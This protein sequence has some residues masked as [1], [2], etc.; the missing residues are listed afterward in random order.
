MSPDMVHVRYEVSA[1]NNLVLVLG[2]GLLSA[3]L[4]GL[5][6]CNTASFCEQM[7][8]CSKTN[9]SIC[10]FENK[11]SITADAK[12]GKDS[13]VESLSTL[14]R[15]LCSPGDRTEQ[16]PYT[17]EVV[18]SPFFPYPS[19]I[20]SEIMDLNGTTPAT[21]ACGKWIDAGG[22]SMFISKVS[23]R[24]SY[25]NA[26]WINS[27]TKA[28]DAATKDPRIATTSM[29]KFRAECRRTTLAGSAAV[30]SAAVLAYEYFKN[31]IDSNTADRQGFL[32]SIGFQMG[33]RCA[34][35][36]MAGSY[37]QSTIAFK[38]YLMNGYTFNSNTLSSA[39][40]MFSESLQLQRD[41]EEAN[42]AIRAIYNSYV[43]E[44]STKPTTENLRDLMEGATGL[45]NLTLELTTDNLKLLSAAL[46]YYDQNFSK[47]RA[48]LK[49]ISAFCAYNPW[50][51][52]LESSSTYTDALDAEMTKIKSD[53]LPASGLGRLINVEEEVGEY[54]SMNATTLTL[55]HVT[56]TY[57]SGNL[58]K[59]CLRL[60]RIIFTDEVEAAR[61]DATVPREF[62]DRL[63]NLVLATRIGVG[64]AAHTEPLRSVL[65]N[66]SLFAHRAA[67]AGV[68]I[69]GAPRG[70]WAGLARSIVQ[71]DISSSD[72]MFIQILKQAR[73]SF[74]DEVVTVGLSGNTSPCDHAPFSSQTTW[75]AY[76][77]KEMD[78]S[79]YFLGIMHR[80]VGDTNYNDATLIS[81]FLHI[82]AHEL[83]HISES[84]GWN[85]NRFSELLHHYHNDTLV[86]AMAD[87]VGA[88]AVLNTGMVSKNDFKTLFCQVW[89]SR[90]PFGW[91]HP[92]T[93]PPTVHPSG[94]SRCNNLISTLD[95]F[96]PT[97]GV[98]NKSTASD[99]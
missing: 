13:S 74:I 36:T 79:V 97:L 87:V 77:L 15:G 10:G 93:S 62:Y 99:T 57:S 29:A 81:R 63:Q 48:Y 16:N 33:H 5:S 85:N 88:V 96:F 50:S 7:G 23:R 98:S 24:G 26:E 61:F 59:D 39:L 30:R 45:G 25:D 80:P 3:F 49:G 2:G 54:E 94:N 76:V 64:I 46:K 32:R 84:V 14:L 73:V 69:V 42:Q 31:Y 78:C 55:A 19:G 47:A 17:G 58:D 34:G 1:T 9:Y 90:E 56:P 68:R 86:E 83:G 95:E 11:V 8:T 66:A 27:L 65:I 72:G 22:P 20:N 70:S 21:I 71:T 43:E 91:M 52:L 6:T 18:C 41:A 82:V 37:V 28:E 12:M 51:G 4:C 89:C 67:N 92:V 35:T 40:A 75:N 60:M 44:L 38:T 53:R